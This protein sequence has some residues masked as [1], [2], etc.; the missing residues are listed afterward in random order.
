MSLSPNENWPNQDAI[1]KRIRYPGQDNPW[2]T[3]VGVVK[4][5]KHYGLDQPMRPGRFF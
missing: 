1:G 2:L 3:V 4:D 5:E